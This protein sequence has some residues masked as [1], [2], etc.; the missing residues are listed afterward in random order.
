MTAQGDQTEEKT[1]AKITVT[2][3]GPYIVSGGVPLVRK[4]AV[5]TEQGEPVTWKKTAN[6]P[7]SGEYALCRCGH[8]HEKPFCDGTH[9]EIDFDGAE[10]ADPSP[11]SER[12]ATLPGGKGLVVRRDYSLCTEAGFCGNRFTNIDKLLAD[13]EDPN[14]LLQI[15]AMVE[16]CPS[17]SYSYAF[18]EGE[19]DV[20]P[21]LPQQIAVTT[22]MTSDGPIMGPLWVTGWVRLE[23]ADHKPIEARNRVTLCRC[24]LSKNKPLCDGEHRHQHVKE[25]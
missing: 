16:R 10:T 5:V 13:A 2:R 12:R 15:I 7:A 17:G 3:D 18:S 11:V 6:L 8:S 21:D 14:V 9:C 25:D 1:G 23:R 20:E 19:P 24:G 22:E 4:V